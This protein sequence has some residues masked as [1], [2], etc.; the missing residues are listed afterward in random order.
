MMLRF[1]LLCPCAG[2]TPD[3][4]VLWTSFAHDVEPVPTMTTHHR[5]WLAR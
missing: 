4:E 3:S 1:W 5:V 2:A